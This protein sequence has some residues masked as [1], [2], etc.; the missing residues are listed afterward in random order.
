VLKFVWQVA[1]GGQKYSRTLSNKGG[2]M[3]MAKVIN[4]SMPDELLEQMNQMEIVSLQ[5]FLD[6]Y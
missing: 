4:I 3:N 1:Q 2:T 6:I 5:I